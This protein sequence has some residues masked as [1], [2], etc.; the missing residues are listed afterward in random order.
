[1]KKPFPHNRVSKQRCIDCNKPMKKNLLAK[2][3][4]ATRCWVCWRIIRKVFF[5]K[6]TGQDLRN[7]QAKNRRLFSW[8]TK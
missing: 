1:M 8:R 4:D 6:S 7:K 2:N 3:P 5:I